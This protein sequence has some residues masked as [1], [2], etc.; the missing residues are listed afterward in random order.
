LINIF[1]YV[2][3]KIKGIYNRVMAKTTETLY[4]YC[5]VYKMTVKKDGIFCY[6][7]YQDISKKLYY[8][9]SRDKFIFTKDNEIFA[10]NRQ[11]LEKHRIQLFIEQEPN[12]RENGYENIEKAITEFDKAFEKQMEKI[13]TDIIYSI[14][15]DDSRKLIVKPRNGNYDWIYRAGMAVEWDKNGEFLIF[16][17]PNEWDYSHCFTQIKEAVLSEYGTKLTVDK[18]TTF[19]NISNDLEE[20]IK[21][22]NI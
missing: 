10:K 3:K 21:N 20:N 15:I 18:K 14:K 13:K 5:P 22:G 17:K 1:N 8:V 2:D 4:L 9:Q 7:I 19:E 6:Q 16:N 11:Q 12:T